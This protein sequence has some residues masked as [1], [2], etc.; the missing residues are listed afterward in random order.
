MD[1]ETIHGDGNIPKIEIF[2]SSISNQFEIAMGLL[3][4]YT[5]PPYQGSFA[6]IVTRVVEKQ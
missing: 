5:W 1:H 2:A 3:L 6:S 4:D